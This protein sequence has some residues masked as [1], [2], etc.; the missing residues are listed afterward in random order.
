MK[1]STATDS[2]APART[3]PALL[4]STSSAPKASRVAATAVAQPAGVGDV[5]VDEP[6]RGTER[7]RHGPALVA[8]DVAE[9]HPGTAGDEQTSLGLALTPGPAAD[10]GDAPVEAGA[11][12]GLGRLTAPRSG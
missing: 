8:E 10:Q 3:M 11:V 7:G 4:T 5:E 2:M 6:G 9:H 1:S 12:G